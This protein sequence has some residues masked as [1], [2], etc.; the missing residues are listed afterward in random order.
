MKQAH[1]KLP[2][3]LWHQKKLWHD[4]VDIFLLGKQEATHGSRYWSFPRNRSL[5]LVH[6]THHS[7]YLTHITQ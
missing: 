6:H 2:L 7:H 1:R 3:T 5:C 4:G